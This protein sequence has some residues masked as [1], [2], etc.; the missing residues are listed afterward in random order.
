MERLAVQLEL[1]WDVVADD[2]HVA[3]LAHPD[4]GHR[5]AALVAGGEGTDLL[6]HLPLVE[7]PSILRADQ[8]GVGEMAFPDGPV[9]G[10]DGIEQLLG[11]LLQVALGVGRGRQREEGQ[12]EQDG[13]AGS[14]HGIPPQPAGSLSSWMAEY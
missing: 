9:A 2:R 12:A 4:V 14:G 6:Q 1:L 10:G 7:S 8:A 13:K 5:E 11:D 3:M